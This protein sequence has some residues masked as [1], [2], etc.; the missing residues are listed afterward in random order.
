MYL[1][2]LFWHIEAARKQ[3]RVVAVANCC[4]SGSD[5]QVQIAAVVVQ[6]ADHAFHGDARAKVNLIMYVVCENYSKYP[7]R[8]SVVLMHFHFKRLST[9]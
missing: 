3:V 8:M 6:R 1:K 9:K 7:R 2:R 4:R 5:V